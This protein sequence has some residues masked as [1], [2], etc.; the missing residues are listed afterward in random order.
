MP[1]PIGS[2]R[3]AEPTL[4]G[5]EDAALSC[6]A[7]AGH[8]VLE[9]TA[10]QTHPLRLAVLRRGTPSR[11]VAFVEDE[12]ATTLHLGVELD[13]VVVAVSTWIHKSHP[14]LPSIPG[15]QLRGMATVPDL[16]GQGIGG[17]LVETGVERM[18]GSGRDLIWARARDT[19][20]E[21]YERHGFVRRGPGYVDVVTGIPH[22]DIVRRR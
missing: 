10:A 22:H 18:F 15:A 7:V 9:L 12:L 17:E 11:D 3:S 19:A 6:S 16:Q 1:S 21:F 20:L 2:S 5:I 13:G 14:D 4:T 8:R